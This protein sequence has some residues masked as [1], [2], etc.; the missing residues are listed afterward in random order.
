MSA[1]RTLTD[2]IRALRS[3]DV[4]V[5]PAE[6]IDAARAMRLVGYQDRGHLKRTLRPA[7]AKSVEEQAAY[8]RL[9][10]LF[11]RR[12]AGE[13]A[14]KAGAGDETEA[15]TGSEPGDGATYAPDLLELAQ[16]GDPG[17]VA[18]ALER[19]GRAVGLETIRFSTQTGYFAQQMLKA[20]GVEALETRLL[21]RLKARTP[22]A[23]AE[24]ET[25]MAARREMMARARAHAEA[26][27]EVF[28]RGATEA[29]REDVL[30]HKPLGA[31]ERADYERMRALV[32]KV[33]RRLAEKHA[34]RRRRHATGELDVRRTL[35]ANA[36]IGGVP[37]QLHWKQRRRDRPSIVA[38][39]DVSGSVARSV[40]FLLL[41]LH[42]LDEVIPQLRSFCFSGRLDEVTDRLDLDAFE[43]AM[44]AIINDIG[45]S[46]TDYG[47]AL[48]DLVTRYP[49]AIDRRTTVILLGDG[50]SNNGDPRLD[51]FRDIASRARRVVW[52]TPEGP[53][54]WGT[55]DSELLR[56]RP[57]C[58]TMAHVQ[59]LKDLERALD[60]VL[61][62]QA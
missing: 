4:R 56:Y 21:E 17:E 35:R 34:R 19:A 46:P 51:L 11:F 59:S 25:L 55:G 42:S 60:R 43:A 31:L 5:S 36:G 39:C 50:R 29:F 61:T 44:G 12:E 18:M 7:L 32:A 37:F 24:A 3:A 2:F 15:A 48:S 14:G 33:A 58:T 8:D 13:A 6:A 26:Q 62:H 20:M 57:H 30:A 27:F 38:L 23:D 10:D 1:E 49:D 41:L 45:M 47:Q 22:E 54:L 53:A 16:S 28:G 40:R 52:L 9:F